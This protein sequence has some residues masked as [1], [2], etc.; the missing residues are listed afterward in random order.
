MTHN[1]FDKILNATYMREQLH[2][3]RNT[4][5]EHC[6][7][8]LDEMEAEDPCFNGVTHF[9][10]RFATR[11]A[12]F[13]ASDASGVRPRDVYRLLGGEEGAFDIIARLRGGLS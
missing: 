7:Q 1:T 10:L 8:C 12:V 5:M 9:H 11:K 13:M 4:F 3:A 2:K 6:V